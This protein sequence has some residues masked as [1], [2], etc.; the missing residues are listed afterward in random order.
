MSARCLVFVVREGAALLGAV[1]FQKLL[2]T[3]GILVQ[4]GRGVHL[5]QASHRATGLHARGFG[6]CWVCWH[7]GELRV[8]DAWGLRATSAG[9]GQGAA[10]CPLGAPGGVGAWGA[11][12]CRA[13][14]CR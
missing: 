1:L 14:R 8:S 5:P 3:F 13:T 12:A 4:E 9:P 7:V 6:G 11:A 10:L 2:L